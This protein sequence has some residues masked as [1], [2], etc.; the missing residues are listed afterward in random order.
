MRV[1][2]LQVL[3]DKTTYSCDSQN[4][5]GH[6]RFSYFSVKLGEDKRLAEPIS[7]GLRKDF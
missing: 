1:Y 3:Q 5:V 7:L 4:N 6:I 2:I